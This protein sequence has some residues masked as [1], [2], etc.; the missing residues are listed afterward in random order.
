MQLIKII[1]IFFYVKKPKILNMDNY[2]DSL[3]IKKNI[4]F[5]NGSLVEFLKNLIALLLLDQQVLLLRR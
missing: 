2:I 5:C 3:N 1:K 4:I